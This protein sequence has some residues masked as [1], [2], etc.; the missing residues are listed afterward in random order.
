MVK[1]KFNG[2]ACVLGLTAVLVNMITLPLRGLVLPTVQLLDTPQA[3]LACD[4]ICDS[5]MLTLFVLQLVC[6]RPASALATTTNPTT[7]LA[8]IAAAATAATTTSP[9]RV[10]LWIECIAFVPLDLVADVMMG[11][12]GNF[13]LWRLNHVLAI[14]PFLRYLRITEGYFWRMSVQMRR[15]MYIL[16][17]LPMCSHWFACIWFYIAYVERHDTYSWTNQAMYPQFY[18]TSTTTKYLRSIYWSATM[19]T[20]VGFGDVTAVTRV[21]TFM[22]ILVGIRVIYMGILISCASIACVLKLME[23]ADRNQ[24]AL[25]ERLD[26]VCG[27][28]EWRNASDDLVDRA[29]SSV[30]ASFVPQIETTR[31]ELATQLPHALRARLQIE[32]EE[33]LVHTVPRFQ[34]ASKTL[35]A[36]ISEHVVYVSKAPG[37]VLLAEGQAL[38]GI[39][40]LQRGDATYVLGGVVVKALELHEYFGED[41]LFSADEVT[42]Y[43]VVCDS[44]CEFVF[45]GRSHFQD[46]WQLEQDRH[47]DAS[48]G[49][50][51]DSDDSGG[52]H[53]LAK[54]AATAMDSNAATSTRRRRWCRV[55]SADWLPNS[56]F[57][58][59]W[60]LVC[61]GGLLYNIYAV[62]RDCAF[63]RS[64][65]RF[66]DPDAEALVDLGLFWGFDLLFL[67]DFFLHCRRFYVE[68]DGHLVTDRRRLFRRYTRSFWCVIDVVSILPLDLICLGGWYSMRDLPFFRVNKIVRL[69]HLTEYFEVAEAL[70]LSRFHV[71][72]FSRRIFRIVSILILSGYLVGCFWYYIAEITAVV[73]P[74][75][76]WVHVDQSNPRFYFKSY[77]HNRFYVLRSMYFGYIGGS[78]LGFGD[79]VPV[80][81]YETMIATIMLLYGAILKPAL[82]GGVASLLLT[83]NKT[84]VTHQKMLWLVTSH[85]LPE[86]LK[87]RV[88]GYFEF[89]WEHEYYEKEASI[90]E[91]A[92]PDLRW[93]IVQTMCRNDDPNAYFF[94]HVNEDGM[95]AVYAA[96]TPQL[97][98]PHEVIDVPK[99]ALGILVSGHM[100]VRCVVTALAGEGSDDHEMELDETDSLLRRTFGLDTFLSFGMEANEEGRIGGNHTTKTSFRSG[101]DFCEVLWLRAKDVADILA[102]QMS[103]WQ[104]L[105]HDMQLSLASNIA[106]NDVEND[107]ND[108]PGGGGI[109]DLMTTT[110]TKLGELP[111]TVKSSMQ[112]TLGHLSWPSSSHVVPMA[113]TPQLFPFEPP[114]GVTSAERPPSAAA[115]S[116]RPRPDRPRKKH[117]KGKVAKWTPTSKSTLEKDALIKSRFHP[118]SRFRRVLNVLVVLALLYNAFLVPF[119]LAFFSS[120]QPVSYLYGFVVDYV[121]DGLFMV[122]IAMKYRYHLLRLRQDNALLSFSFHWTVWQSLKWDIVCGFPVEV[123]AIDFVRRHPEQLVTVL[124]VCRIPKVFRLRYFT[125]RIKELA[126]TACRNRPQW[127]DFVVVCRYFLF[128]LFF[129]HLLAC[130]WHYLAFA[131]KGLFPWYTDCNLLDNVHV[132][133]DSATDE[134]SCLFAGTWV[135]YQIHGL[136]LPKDGGTIWERYSR[137]FNYAIQMLLVVS[138]GIIVPVN[139]VET[140]FCIGAIFAGI[141]FSAGKIG[142]I[143]EIILK[144]DAASTSIRQATDALAKY[145]AFHKMPQHLTDKA[146]GFMEFLY[147]KR[148]KLLFQEDEIIDM[149]PRQ[150]RDAIVD[151]CKRTR[152]VQSDLFATLPYEVVAAMAKQLKP[153][154][155]APGDVLV[156][157]QRYS[158]SMFFVKPGSVQYQDPSIATKHSKA[159]DVFGARSLLLDEPHPHTI[160]ACMFT[161]AY[162]L[163]ETGIEA[164]FSDF[165]ELKQQLIDRIDDTKTDDLVNDD[166]VLVAEASSSMTVDVKSD[167]EEAAAT[168]MGRGRSLSDSQDE[169][170]LSGATI[171]RTWTEPDSRFRRAW[172]GVLFWTTLYILIMLPLRATYLVEDRVDTVHE[173]AVWYG[174]DVLAQLLYALDTYWSYNHFAFMDHSKMI[175]HRLKIREN[176]RSYLL[177]D[178]VSI[179]PY[180]LGSFVVGLPALKFLVMPLL[181]RTKRFPRY[182][183]RFSRN[184]QFFVCRLSG[185]MLHILHCILYY[186]IMVHWWACLW[187][188]LHRYVEKHSALTWAVRDPYMGGGKLSVWDP[189]TNTHNICTSMIDCYVRAYYFVITFIGTV[190][191]G[192]IRTGGHLEYFFENV[193]ALCGSFLFA[194][195]TSCFA[196]YFQYAD[197]FGKGA[198]QAKLSTLASY[199]RVAHT[200]KPTAR[201]IVANMKLWC[202]RTGGGLVEHAVAAYL[203]VPLRVE[204]ATFV[205]RRL[206]ST[207]PVLSSVDSYIRDL[208]VLTLHFQVVLAGAS[209][210]DA[211]DSLDEVA[212]VS[213]G[214][215]KLV[216]LVT[217]GGNDDDGHHDRMVTSACSHDTRVVV[218]D[219]GCHV[220]RAEA[221]PCLHAVAALEHVELYVLDATGKRDVLSHMPRESRQAFL[222]HLDATSLHASMENQGGDRE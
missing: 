184:F 49:D 23:H 14:V 221:G 48:M 173:L 47:P 130:G 194:A 44:A 163:R 140:I 100:V 152:L 206:L 110:M 137:C 78:T 188:F 166:V 215:V 125:I 27:Y 69:L 18:N 91:E 133:A 211:G 114:T 190:G 24:M 143:G 182:L 145:M 108:D 32:H 141:F 63:F 213:T 200:T 161:E 76:N 3:L 144:V 79:I 121:L 95:R 60:T 178:I 164:V 212:F 136:Y 148:R 115:P 17:I 151:H 195:L 193:E 55:T 187:M 90:L 97:C 57:R 101:S 146:L 5:V 94:R 62:P 159:L 6:C 102:S 196:S 199:F 176:Y 52:G 7:S 21:E 50:D 198:T 46:M 172:D 64:H 74:D 147:R 66:E 218:G 191:L 80:N 59:L 22:S 98:I 51:V 116:S 126:Q 209:M 162:V 171:A 38:G 11:F 82:V 113:S 43:A 75:A 129:S 19:L 197:T 15:T 168:P 128:I 25:Q 179:A 185:S 53:I 89:M 169:P 175:R 65:N 87:D 35:R 139:M 207:S 202:H 9:Q 150:L 4:Y 155:V 149:L 170:A 12:Q 31:A 203:P 111:T 71:H 54:H 160:C 123:F 105:R 61:F 174:G 122:D 99:G 56:M 29:L 120:L 33:V 216:V 109:V 204:M 189:Q 138:A 73:Y 68:Y 88:L 222:A 210:Y 135:E 72:V 220:G 96:M 192:D 67:V 219:A 165:P 1:I 28:L 201:A 154:A 36:A 92:V 205:T 104:S 42:P 177:L 118:K 183:R 214:S 86:A 107:D 119:R 34:T 112:A 180:C 153:R 77:A 16:T 40:L 81:P 93:E 30:R 10:R 157:A 8:S 124:T 217:K 103:T 167:D 106:T 26:D 2:V 83:R 142:V 181:L 186:V 208:L 70:L 20:T 158:R 156:E 58:R 134:A 132:N 127:S 39:Y 131:D 45:L 85:K 41:A 117:R 13:G 37:D 84:Q